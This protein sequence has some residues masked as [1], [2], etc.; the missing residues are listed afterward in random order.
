MEGIHTGEGRNLSK[1][2]FLFLPTT[3]RRLFW[4]AKLLSTDWKNELLNSWVF[5]LMP[6]NPDL[7]SAKEV[8]FQNLNCKN[9]EKPTCWKLL[10]SRG[11]SLVVW[12]G[13]LI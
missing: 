4:Q 7:I 13:E 12:T 3:T 11:T 1:D 10:T 9:V 2:C 6:I 5:S 8:D